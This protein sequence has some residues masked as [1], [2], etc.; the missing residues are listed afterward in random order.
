MQIDQGASAFLR[1]LTKR[2]FERRMTFAAG[3]AENVAHQ[4]VGMHAD[5]HGTVAVLD[6]TPDQR[7][8]RLAAIDL[9]F[10]GD[11]AELAKPGIDQSLADAMHIA[12]M[13]HPIADEFS[14]SQHLQAV[15]PAE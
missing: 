9:T 11:Q 6:F 4:A 8:V 2:A 1:Y 10:I 12:L 7:D 3:G 5:E 14:H 15:F 13:R